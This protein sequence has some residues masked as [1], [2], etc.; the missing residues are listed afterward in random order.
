MSIGA[1]QKSRYR[2]IGDDDITVLLLSLS[3]KYTYRWDAYWPCTLN[4]S[5][6]D[7]GASADTLIKLLQKY[8]K[9]SSPALPFYYFYK[10]HGTHL[11]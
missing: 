4:T 2:M 8:A 5:I 11:L 10:I 9:T 3:A 7:D 6:S 1:L